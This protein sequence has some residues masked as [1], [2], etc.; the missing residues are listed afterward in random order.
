MGVMMGGAEPAGTKASNAQW[1]RIKRILDI[2][3]NITDDKKDV[4][5]ACVR[6]C[7]AY[8]CCCCCSPC[9]AAALGVLPVWS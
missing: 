3:P 5:H 1:D 8:C 2:V 4:R 6:A 7:M 9:A